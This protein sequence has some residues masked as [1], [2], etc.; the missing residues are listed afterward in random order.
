M[1]TRNRCFSFR[2]VSHL[3]TLHLLTNLLVVSR[4]TKIGL[5]PGNVI[6]EHYNLE[7]K[8]NLADDE[9]NK[10][11]FE[12][13]VEILVQCLKPTDTIVLNVLELT[14]LDSINITGYEDSAHDTCVKKWSL[15]KKNETLNVTLCDSLRAGFHYNI[16]IE[17]V[18][19]ITNKLVGYYRSS[20]FDNKSNQTQWLA[21][22]HFEPTHARR[23]F[24][25]FDEPSFKATFQISIGRMEKYT[26]ISNEVVEKT[27]PMKDSKGWF[28][29]RYRKSVKMST[30]MVAYVVSDFKFTTA[31]PISGNSVTF[32]VWCREDAINQT[33]FA[34]EMGPKMLATFEEYLN[35]SLP[36]PKQDM[37][38]I[39]DLKVDAMGNWGLIT[40]RENLLL[41]DRK[42][43]SFFDQL[44]AARVVGNK[45][46]HQWF[47][48][49]VTMKWWSDLWLKEGFSTYMGAALVQNVYPQVDS[50]DE[51]TLSN[52]R[53]VFSFD[54]LQDS[55]PISQP[56]RT[57]G[58]IDAMFDTI[59]YKKGSSILFTAIDILGEEA[60][61]VGL[62]NYLLKHMYDNVEQDDLF[63]SL[64]HAGHTMGVLEDDLDFKTILDTWTLQ[65]GYPVVTVNRNYKDN[66]L[67]VT[68]RRYYQNPDAPHNNGCWWIPLSYTNKQ[69]LNFTNTHPKAWQ[70][71]P[72]S[73]TIINNVA[74]KDDWILIN[75]R[76]TGLYRVNYDDKS[77][78]MLISELLSDTYRVVPVM[79]RAQLIED[80]AS[81]AAVSIISYK[82]FFRLL[83]YLKKEMRY[84]PWKAAD[85]RIHYLHVMLRYTSIYPS[86]QKFVRHILEEITKKMKTKKLDRKNTENIRL[87]AL[88]G[89]LCCKYDVGD[90]RDKA[91][92]EAYIKN[93]NSRW[94]NV[95]KYMHHVVL[96]YGIQKGNETEWNLLWQ[97]YKKSNTPTEKHLILKSLGCTKIVPLLQRYL[98]WTL[99]DKSGIRKHDRLT[100]FTAVAQ[101]D[102][103]YHY[104]E[105][106]L[107]NY[108]EEIYER[109]KPN[110]NELSAYLLVI[111]E[112]ITTGPG[113]DRLKY[114]TKKYSKISELKGGLQR[115]LETATINIRW[116]TLFFNN[117]E[118]YF[119]IGK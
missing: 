95:P 50:F 14:I 29:D 84:L 109:M 58:E 12:G 66:S 97:R 56:V 35:V 52:M 51:S 59:S 1:S 39:P 94:S 2:V 111:A 57:T 107:L 28:W 53:S 47:G 55:H 8:T 81:L 114:L 9:K 105:Q 20:Y 65:A 101:N 103:G 108:I 45:I 78:E 44:A 40:C 49:L 63:E 60:G 69:E 24:P 42:S 27:E 17:F 37:V 43:S 46:A 100:V 79:N 34:S 10:F 110:I 62:T 83:H 6:P 104:A 99:N 74:K 102:V 38:A 68:Q 25:C 116:H 36:I 26:S 71:C 119:E 13:C 7:I 31:K 118:N 93:P 41:I 4:G 67:R 32:R 88:I 48:N 112:Q 75:L 3:T 23:A 91:T 117:I 5:L 89:S 64:T 33:K 11:T 98:E 18:G 61:T 77:W 70:T 16:S 54:G 113:L 92:L 87:V 86:F 106:F 30:Y 72:K 90:C 76:G 115:A 21:V 82:Y 96:C 80:S 22:T 73:E 19:N 85:E 15:E